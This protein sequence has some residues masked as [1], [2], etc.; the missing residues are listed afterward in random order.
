[1]SLITHDGVVKDVEDTLL[2]RVLRPLAD[3]HCIIFH[4]WILY[5]VASLDYPGTKDG[6]DLDWRRYGDNPSTY[7]AKFRGVCPVD[8]YKELS[9]SMPAGE[10][11]LVY[12][13]GD[14]ERIYRG[15]APGVVVFQ[16]LK[17]DSYVEHRIDASGNR[18]S[19]EF[20]STPEINISLGEVTALTDINAFMS[21]HNAGIADILLDNSI[22]VKKKGQFTN[23]SIYAGI[24]GAA[25][26]FDTYYGDIIRTYEEGRISSKES[27]TRSG[28]NQSYRFEH[29]EGNYDLKEANLIEKVTVGFSCNCF[30]A[31]IDFWKPKAKN[32]S[33]G[34]SLPA[35]LP[36]FVVYQMDLRGS[37]YPVPGKM[38]NEHKYWIENTDHGCKTFA[39]LQA[40]KYTF[41]AGTYDVKDGRDLRNWTFTPG[42]THV[43]SCMGHT[44]PH[45]T[46]HELVKAHYKI[47]EEVC[48][49]VADNIA[50]NDMMKGLVPA[51]DDNV[52]LEEAAPVVPT[53]ELPVI[54]PPKV[55]APKPAANVITVE[56]QAVK[57]GIDAAIKTCQDLAKT[58]EVSQTNLKQRIGELAERA[59]K[60][61][62]LFEKFLKLEQSLRESE[63]AD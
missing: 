54:E 53:Y 32:A 35:V 47:F 9:D 45:F 29:I 46:S 55:E 34:K 4:N 22:I 21:S 26:R 49:K 16:I 37:L 31:N 8:T 3:E 36:K 56:P 38:H 40:Y 58:W 27:P 48:A 43:Y 17:T 12:N 7:D 51:D 25:A 6:S 60:F 1:M 2:K 18:T 63:A 42:E 50:T 13:I 24:N 61:E 59:D 19:T 28:P 52:V 44:L 62:A 23:V 10:S 39:E 41:P 11:L 30:N 15:D 57:D 20:N 33:D 14:N 5:E